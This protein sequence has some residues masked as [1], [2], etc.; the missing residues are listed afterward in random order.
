MKKN[1]IN[2][3]DVVIFAEGTINENRLFEGVVVKKTCF[4]FP[5]KYHVLYLKDD[6]EQINE[7]LA[8]E[9]HLKNTIDELKLSIAKPNQINTHS[10]LLLTEE[11]HQDKNDE[12]K[13]LINSILKWWKDHEFDTYKDDNEEYNIYGD[14][15]EFVKL[16]KEF[17]EK[18]DKL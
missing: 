15:P 14:A 8:E 1:K 3:G 4:I 10:D 13:L 16:A 7:F 18:G 9:L 5:M 12:I 17:D 2:V 11:S 6:R